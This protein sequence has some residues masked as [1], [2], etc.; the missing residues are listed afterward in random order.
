MRALISAYSC[1][2]DEGSEPGVGWAVLLGAASTC[3]QVVL[4]TRANN[5]TAVED[6]LAHRRVENVSVVGFDLWRWALRLKRKLPLG[7]TLYYILWQLQLPRRV[8]RRLRSETFDI[9]HHVTF[10][11]D[12]LPAGIF[13][14][15]DGVKLWGPVGGA[16]LCPPE[17]YRYLGWRGAL[18]EIARRVTGD[19]GR[20][21]VGTRQA[22]LSDRI[23]AQNPDVAGYFSSRGT[24]HPEVEP[25][26]FIDPTLVSAGSDASICR[27]LIVGVGRL[28]PWK[29]WALALHSLSMLPEEYRLQ[30][31]GQGSDLARLNRLARRLGVDNRV[32]F[33]GH[34]AR[35]EVVRAI[36]RAEAIVFPSFH[37]S[38]PGVVGEAV[39][40]SKPLVV[41]D[42]AGSG[43]MAVLAGVQPV[44]HRGRDL[45]SRY[46]AA[47]QSAR[48][49]AVPARF[50]AERVP[51]L[52][53]DWYGAERKGA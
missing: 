49:P 1:D 40:L 45:P 29:G 47:I 17:L 38:A 15:A 32:E 10:A 44:E 9:V 4:V 42:L 27:G 16:S 37:D 48:P 52:V 50:S 19:V 51:T 20:R 39:A 14:A 23:L 41:L 31:Y 43:Y 21:L 12:W 46:A 30:L 5:V 22:H 26:A 8:G 35:T 53:A 18:S 2:P 7:H 11:S 28:V 24:V 25:N 34:V 36:A 13:G 6:A 3:S 33:M